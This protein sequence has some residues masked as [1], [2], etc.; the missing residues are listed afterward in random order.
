MKGNSEF[1]KFL[2]RYEPKVK[3]TEREEVYRGLPERDVSYIIKDQL[4]GT[5]EKTKSEY[6]NYL[7]I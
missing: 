5:Y 2:A 4:R 3:I 7:S 6:S 1:L